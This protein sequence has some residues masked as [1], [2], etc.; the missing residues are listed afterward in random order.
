MDPALALIVVTALCLAGGVAVMWR[1]RPRPERRLVE[2][3]DVLDLEPPERIARVEVW[4]GEA[5]RR[6][7]ERAAGLIVQGCAWLDQ[8]C[9]ER[10]ARPFQ[11][12]Y[13]TRPTY[14]IAMVLAFSCMKVNRDTVA[15]LLAKVVET[16]DECRRPALGTSRWEQ[17]LLDLCRSGEG[18]QGGSALAWALRSLPSRTLR[19]QIEAALAD[20]PTWAAPLVG[21][22]DVYTDQ[23][24]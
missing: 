12:A 19:Q 24:A 5:G 14:P 17:A 15:Q 7:D 18:A 16:W 2:L 8:G 20:R 6:R 11:I 13:H 3:S 10:A 21:E 22:D 23:G 1:R 9:P 4:L